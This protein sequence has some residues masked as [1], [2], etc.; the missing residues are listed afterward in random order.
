MDGEWIGAR[1][2]GRTVGRMDGEIRETG[3]E[4]REINEIRQIREIER[5]SER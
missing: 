3:E 4:I 2:G 5:D 1:M